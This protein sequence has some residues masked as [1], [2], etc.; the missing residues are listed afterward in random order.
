MS[1]EDAQLRRMIELYVG[2]MNAASATEHWRASIV[3][4][5]KVRFAW[6]AASNPVSRTTTAHGR[7]C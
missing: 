3:Q 5:S 1:A 7:R 4:V 6:Q 2:R